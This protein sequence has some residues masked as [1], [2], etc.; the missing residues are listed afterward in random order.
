MD[1]NITHDT[2]PLYLQYL[3]EG[4]VSTVWIVYDW[5]KVFILPRRLE[6]N[7]VSMYTSKTFYSFAICSFFVPFKADLPRPISGSRDFQVVVSA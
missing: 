5:I 3:C 2:S 7:F 4:E 1:I 6:V